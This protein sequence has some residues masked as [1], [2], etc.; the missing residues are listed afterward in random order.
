MSTPEGLPLAVDHSISSPGLPDLPPPPF[1]D[2]AKSD[3]ASMVPPTSQEPA[4]RPPSSNDKVTDASRTLTP[5]VFDASNAP[6]S[7]RDPASSTTT[8]DNG[9]STSRAVDASTT[10]SGDTE[11]DDDDDETPVEDDEDAAKLSDEALAFLETMLPEFLGLTKQA[12]R[13]FWPIVLPAFMAKFPG[14]LELE[15][16]RKVKPVKEK[17]EKEWKAMSNK[18]RRAF[19]ARLK[20][21]K[22]SPTKRL[23]QR[24]KNWYWWRLGR[25]KG[26]KKPFQPLFDDMKRGKQPPRRRQLAHIVM[27]EFTEEVKALSKETS[28]RDQL[29]CRTAAARDM[30]KSME[31]QVHS[32]LMKKREDEFLSRMRAYK[33]QQAT[34][35]QGDEEEEEDGDEGEPLSGNKP[36]LPGP[37]PAPGWSKMSETQRAE[38]LRCREG[39]IPIVQP[40]LDGLRDLTGYSMVLLA[41]VC[42]DPKEKRFTQATVH[43]KPQNMPDFAEHSGEKFKEFGKLFWRWVRDIKVATDAEPETATISDNADEAGPGSGTEKPGQITQAQPAQP[44]QNGQQT[45]APAIEQSKDSTKSKKTKK[46]KK[47]EHQTE[48]V[49]GN[50][51]KGVRSRKSGKGKKRADVWDS[52]KAEESSDDEVEGLKSTKNAERNVP[53]PRPVR[54]SNRIQVNEQAS[55]EPSKTPLSSIENLPAAPPDLP[56]LHHPKVYALALRYVYD[57]IKSIGE[58]ENKLEDLLGNQYSWQALAPLFNAVMSGEDGTDSC[59]GAVKALESKNL[60]LEDVEPLYHPEVYRLTRTF[61]DSKM[62]PDELDSLLSGLLGERYTSQETV[63]PLLDMVIELEKA[64]EDVDKGIDEMEDIYLDRLHRLVA[65]KRASKEGRGDVAGS[66]NPAAEDDFFPTDVNRNGDDVV[67]ED[68]PPSPPAVPPVASPLLPIEDEEQLTLEKPRSTL[69]PSESPLSPPQQDD[70]PPQP[71]LAPSSTHST[72]P[73]TPSGKDDSALSIQ[74]SKNSSTLEGPSSTLGVLLSPHQRE[75]QLP[76]GLLTSPSESSSGSSS[77]P[78]SEYQAFVAVMSTIN[79]DDL[80]SFVRFTSEGVEDRF[81]KGHMAYLLDEGKEKPPAWERLVFKWIDV[82]SIWTSREF[83]DQDV[84]KK[85]R[86]ESVS[87]WF[88]YGRLRTARTPAG[89]T[90][91]EMEAEWWQWWTNANPEWRVKVDGK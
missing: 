2:G 18:A 12:R 24:I 65:S 80:P 63:A 81:I 60:F 9:P 61:L 27:D 4:N 47:G 17:T 15:K 48:R 29:A 79:M 37:S 28:H 1:L 70:T 82:E 20:R 78:T 55:K 83:N 45:L 6:P 62:L 3:N 50:S 66:A 40:F 57:D 16:T 73:P 39:F 34:L 42:T 13:G 76:G 22:Y 38:M 44:Q 33:G 26:D 52:D 90:V 36:E 11:M 67:M 30:I 43:S 77:T 19:N 56:P 58:L 32:A 91:E 5:P 14:E 87:W 31:P 59:A 84:S 41:G 54:R 25:K 21:S 88:S 86:P 69:S 51:K 7:S 72:P 71:L 68:A 23:L 74:A 10:P 89:V 8:A 46:S 53:R 49:E 64:G 75:I 35:E 85:G